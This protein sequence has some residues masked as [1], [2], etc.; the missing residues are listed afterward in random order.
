[1][2][3]SNHCRPL[4]ARGAI[5]VEFGLVAIILIPL[6]LGIVEFGRALYAYDTLVK[7][8][9]SAARYLSVGTPSD[10]AR[11]LEAKCIVITGSPANSGGGCS[12][13]LQLPGLTT[14]MVSIL[15]PSASGSV[16]AIATGAGS[17]DAVT[18]SISGYPLSQ[19]APLRYS[20]LQLGVISVTV[21]YVFF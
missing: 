13:P 3:P 12:A 20:G 7:S 4:P 6:V 14:A 10:A 9:R 16:R 21:P 18:V 8:V 17:L 11:Q 19:I 5:A 15:E 1:M 2:H